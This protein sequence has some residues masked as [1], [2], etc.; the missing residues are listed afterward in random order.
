MN[1]VGDIRCRWE[2]K[3][4]WEEPFDVNKLFL[5]IAKLLRNL[6]GSQRNRVLAAG[7]SYPGLLDQEGR[8]TAVNLVWEKF[9][10]IEE[11]QAKAKLHKMTDLP[12]FLEP[13]R[14]SS[15]LAE[16]W[17]GC[18][19]GCENGLL[20]FSE[21]GIGIGMFVDGKP[22]KGARN[23]AGEIG[24]S[25]STSIRRNDAGAGNAAVSKP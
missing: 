23:M 12:I 25:P 15:V 22:V 7:I 20:L 13:D 8:L 11:L 2:E 10:L 17:L 6:D 9:P 4:A 14:H 21:R 19:R 1:L 5:S 3:L 18:A 16:R 24:H